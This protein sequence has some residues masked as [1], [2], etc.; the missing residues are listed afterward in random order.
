MAD[1]LGDG[2]I[3]VG[4]L[5]TC[6]DPAAPT[7][8]EVAAGVDLETF[9]TPDGLQIATTTDAVDASSIA[10]NQY[11]EIPGRR[12]D[13]IVLTFKSQGDSAAP[14]TTFASRAPGYLVVRYGVD[15][16]TDWAAAQTV[17]VYPVTAGDRQRIPVAANEM[18]KFQVPFM[19]SSAMSPSV[20]IAA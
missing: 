1:I 10:S 17:D 4:F 3:K 2:A 12:K 9:I 14:W 15:S 19:V 13:D 8:A 16:G 11:S 5:T 18:L 6:A 20:A 7:A